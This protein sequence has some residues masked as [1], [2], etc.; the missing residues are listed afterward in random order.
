MSISG[1]LWRCGRSAPPLWHLNSVMPL[2]HDTTERRL[3]L[4][5]AMF[6]A[7]VCA[8]QRAAEPDDAF[9]H[10]AHE[11]LKPTRGRMKNFFAG[12]ALCLL[13][14]VA[15][16]ADSAVAPPWAYPATDPGIQR[17]R[18]DGSPK[19]VPGSDKAFTRQ[20]VGNFFGVKDWFP[21]ERPPMPDVVQNG[22]RPDV[23]ACAGCHLPSGLGHPE[24]ADLAGLP[25]EYFFQQVK[26]FQSGKRHNV[27]PARSNGMVTIA[28]GMTDEEIKAAAAYFASLKPSSW[29]KIKETDTVPVTFVGGGNM[30]YVKPDGGNEPIGQRIIEVPEDAERADLRD[31]HSGFVAYVPVGSIKQGEAL[32]TTGGNGKTISCAVCHGP[33][34]KGIG[35]VPGIAGLHPIYIVRQ[36]LDIQQGAR[37]GSQTPLMK[38]VVAKLSEDDIVNIAAYVASRT[39]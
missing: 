20:E 31:T 28:K 8:Y 2:T 17:E 22:H 15:I 37:D 1:T 10:E 21:N 33:D 23:R 12:A 32:V 30:R 26:E 19:H 38:A 4:P 35:N 7:R 39:P 27:L 13:P 9:S 6:L 24:S 36:L 14:A 3:R 11:S 16:A 29:V 5:L 34:L 18:D 25:P